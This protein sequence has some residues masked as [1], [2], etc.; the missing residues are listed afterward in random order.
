[1]NQFD[2]NISII[3]EG[4]QSKLTGAKVLIFGV[5]GV[6]GHVAEALCRAGVGQIDIVD[7]DVVDLTNLNRQIIATHETMG[8]DKV[9]VMKDRMMSINPELKCQAMKLFY[10]PEN[11][12]QI[13]FTGYD[14]VVDAVDT[15]S[16]KIA[17]IEKAKEAGVKVIS[18]MGTAGKMDPGKFQIADISKTSVCPL[19]KVMRKEL[20]NRNIVDVKVLF[21]TEEPIKNPDGGTPGS[22]S[23]VPSVAGLLI[24]GE[25]IKTLISE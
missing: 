13:D 5:G 23:F 20:K 3:G 17:I 14:Y 6:G 16:A 22:L 19:A 10:L 9:T 21:S 8:A 25:V 18:S 11:R 1:M 7:G 15:V 4:A 12:D 2:R 24:G